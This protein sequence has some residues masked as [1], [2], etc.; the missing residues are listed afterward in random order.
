MTKREIPDPSQPT[1]F[2]TS[3]QTHQIEVSSA[4]LPQE[5]I[6]V[7]LIERSLHLQN[8]ITH[9][10][11]VSMRQGFLSF[12]GPAEQSYGE[13]AQRVRQAAERQVAR[14]SQLAKHEFALASGHFT[15]IDASIPKPEV[16]AMTRADYSDFLEKFYGTRHYVAAQ[17]FRRQLAK[18]VETQQAIRAEQSATEQTSLR[19]QPEVAPSVPKE[20]AVEH[21]EIPKLNT[22]ERLRAIS[23]DFRAGFLP[24]THSEKNRVLTFLDYLDNHKFERGINDQLL[25]VFTHAQKPKYAGFKDGKR[26]LESIVF[27]MGD[28]LSN[29]VHSHTALSELQQLINDCP[30]PSVTLAEE[31]GKSHP[32]YGPFVRYVDLSELRD[33]GKAIQVNR[34][35][36]RTGENR[37]TSEGPGRHKTIE[38]KYTA[39]ELKPEFAER[40]A[41]FAK[42]MTIG[43]ARQKILGPLINEERR[44]AFHAAR[45]EDVRAMPGQHISKLL[46]RLT[47]DMLAEQRLD[48]S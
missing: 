5:S 40:I 44:A 22:P 32:G 28:Y 4:A 23:E 18:Y 29:A 31:V 38:D 9:L 35:P 27:E 47:E 17:A 20:D 36:L 6:A 26:A 3:E 2:V 1:L 8:V 12:E 24:A 34:D 48:V 30:N 14:L 42:N 25:E 7:N 39:A 33:K 45:L 10:A 46:L 21:P 37:I 13:N 19:D 15:L 41:N 16:Q 43:E 11:G